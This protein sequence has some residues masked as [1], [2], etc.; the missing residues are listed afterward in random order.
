MGRR[1]E[2]EMTPQEY[3]NI[4]RLIKGAQE[5]E[6]KVSNDFTER[7]M[8]QIAA[9]MLARALGRERRMFF[10]SLVSMVIFAF[11]V[12]WF[13]SYAVPNFVSMPVAGTAASPTPMELLEF[14]FSQFSICLMIA[15][16]VGIL[17]L[18]FRFIWAPWRMYRV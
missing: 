12:G 13:L 11:V 6:P 16:I 14:C 18:V 10:W 2:K 15:I 7:V 3:P 9:R 8:N 5:R 4:H 17:Y 1:M